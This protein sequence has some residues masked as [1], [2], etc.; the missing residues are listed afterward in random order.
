MRDDCRL[1]ARDLALGATVF[2]AL[3]VELSRLRAKSERL[4]EYKKSKVRLRSV[5]AQAVAGS[6]VQIKGGTQ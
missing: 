4:S 1:Y 2:G 6:V 5:V 3:G